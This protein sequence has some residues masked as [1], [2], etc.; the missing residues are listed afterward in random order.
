MLQE[1]E[2]VDQIR[3]KKRFMNFSPILTPLPPYIDIWIFIAKYRQMILT[4]NYNEMKLRTGGYLV[5]DHFGV[6][7]S[8]QKLH[9]DHKL[10]RFFDHKLGTPLYLK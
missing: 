10:N 4:M 2:S 1:N 3:T 5:Y 7:K 9:F 6:K 8:D